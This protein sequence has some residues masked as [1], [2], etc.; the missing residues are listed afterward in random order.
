MT[1]P[2]LVDRLRWEPSPSRRATAVTVAT[3]A[4]LLYLYQHIV[5]RNGPSYALA[6]VVICMLL[7]ATFLRI[8]IGIGALI[9]SMLLSPE[10]SLGRLPTHDLTVRG[11]ELLIPTVIIAW[12]AR[13]ALRGD[14]M[15][16]RTHPAFKW[17]AMWVTVALVSS[18]RHQRG[19]R[20]S[21]R[22]HAHH[23]RAAGVSSASSPSPSSTC[24]ASS[25]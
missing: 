24:A 9:L 14:R 1:W 4:L 18:L 23:R 21:V 15:T 13:A 12:L 16:L 19:P 20:P 3:G 8:E 10:I 17:L 7:L 11:E 25:A 5:Y 6:V 22:Q 2:A